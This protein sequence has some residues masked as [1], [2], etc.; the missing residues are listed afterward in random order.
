MC[1]NTPSPP[2]KA[3]LSAHH[4]RHGVFGED[5][6]LEFSQV[7]TSKG[8]GMTVEDPAGTETEKAFLAWQSEIIQLI[9]AES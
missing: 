6:C 5:S 9:L 4:S 2:Q 7:E 3:A 8:T 1:T